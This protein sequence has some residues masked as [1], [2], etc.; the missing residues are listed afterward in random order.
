M[1]FKFKNKKLILHAFATE[2]DINVYTHFPVTHASKFYPDWWKKL[3][4][5][6]FDWKNLSL[7][8]SMKNCPGLYTMYKNAAI[9]PMWSDLALKTDKENYWYQFF[10][11]KSMCETHHKSQ[12]GEFKRDYIHCKL[13]SPWLF[14]SDKGVNFLFME[15]YWNY[16]EDKDYEVATGM[17]E[18]YYNRTT[19]VI[20]FLSPNKNI[21]IKNNTPIVMIQPI[22]ERSLEIKLE[23]VTRVEWDKVKMRNA[24]VSWDTGY[25]NMI[26]MVDRTDEKNKCP[27]GFGRKK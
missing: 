18:Y 19:N 23:L 21:L 5:G 13:T 2:E 6:D 3:P 27:F 20:V 17:T 1:L 4:A 26:R 15:P 14:K 25:S 16:P 10:D 8:R 22:S 9:I 7:E 11:K 24:P 12:R